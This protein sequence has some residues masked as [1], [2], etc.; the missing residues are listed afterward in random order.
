[1]TQQID[2]HVRPLT[3]LVPDPQNRRTH[4]AKNLAMVVDALQQ[5]GAARS[6]VIDERKTGA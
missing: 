2:G 4:T 5:V 6:I 3:D 1:M